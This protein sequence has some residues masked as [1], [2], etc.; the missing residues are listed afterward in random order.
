MV[1]AELVA[2][3]ATRDQ[4]TSEIER[5]RVDKQWLRARKPTR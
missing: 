4:L 1:E 2:A 5:L 3:Q